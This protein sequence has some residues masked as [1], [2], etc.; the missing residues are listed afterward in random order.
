MIVENALEADTIT[1]DAYLGG[2]GHQTSRTIRPPGISLT[3]SSRS[4]SPARGSVTSLA[5]GPLPPPEIRRP[6][7]LVARLLARS[8]LVAISTENAWKNGGVER[9]R[10]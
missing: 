7:C 6:R 9:C 8:A 1:R 5:A 10:P 2:R 4:P 3:S